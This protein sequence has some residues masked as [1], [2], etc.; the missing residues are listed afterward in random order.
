MSNI[1]V[2]YSGLIS[3]AVGLSSLLTGTIFTLIVTRSLTP[4]EFGTWGLIGGL[5]S[6]VLIAEPIISYWTTRE[7][8]REE[9]SGK[10]AIVT[11]SMFSVIAIFAYI[12]IVYFVS[13]GT[14]ADS[15]VLSFA[16]ILI[17]VMFLNKT[18]TA[19]NL[20]WKPQAKSY[21]LFVFEIV[22]IPTALLFVYF[23]DLS[24]HGA[25]LATLVSYMGSIVVLAIF[26][27]EQI[28]N[29]ISF[30]YLRKWIKLSW[31]SLYPGLSTL[32]F[33]L[34]V[35][36]FS[37][38]TGSV[39]G[40]SYYS[41]SLAVAS[42][43][44]H[45]GLIAQALYAK[46]LGGGKREHLHKNLIRFFYFSFPLTALSIIMAKPGLFALN[47][48]Y[49][50][51]V[52]VVIFLTLRAFL[53]TLS[54]IFENSLKGIETVDM[55]SNQTF[56]AFVKSKLF[57]LPTIRLI[58]YS[59]YAISLLIVFMLLSNSLE[60][61]EL[62]IGWSIISFLIE[63]PFFVYFYLLIRKNFN[64][65]IPIIPITKYII[66]SIGVFLLT[67]FLM[68][69]YLIY[70]NSIFNFLPQVMLFVVFGI[71]LYLGITYF[72][73]ERT[74]NLFNSVIAELKNKE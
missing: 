55:K 65:M 25:I 1:R 60:Q 53:F 32:I 2:T 41:A 37:L 15:D 20:G 3:L 18:L 22:K 28:K 38:I 27:K 7:V 24:I 12:V 67:Y 49:Q 58:K 54:G 30:S 62:I 8:A 68:E 48:L 44:A 56:R 70:E 66:T 11:S 10:T 17:P 64:F 73:D 36:I 34:D 23:L 13:L 5:L 16:L 4:E 14:D 59:S 45:S 6:Y 71:S 42:F 35:A 72:I 51:A 52:P 40:L 21:G 19:I 46:F 29:K 69:K 39:I 43:V 9:K 50:I 31:L 61:I 57:L 47:P 74:K 63:I 33:S 26:A